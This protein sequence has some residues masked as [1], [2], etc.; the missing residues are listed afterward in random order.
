MTS[1]RQDDFF[2]ALLK[3]SEALLEGSATRLLLERILD[4]AMEVTEAER[5]FLFIKSLQREN[6]IVPSIYRNFDP[7]HFVEKERYSI[8]V[9]EQVMQTGE[10][11][12][13]INAEED[14]RF[15]GRESVVINKLTSIICVPIRKQKSVL[16]YIYLDSQERRAHFNLETLHFMRVFANQTAIALEAADFVNRLALENEALKAQSD[17][18]SPFEEIIGESPE[19]QTI[20]RLTQRVMETDIPV[21]ILGE[22]GTGKELIARAIHYRGARKHKP[23]I[24]QFCGALAD[25]LL[26]SELFGYKKGAF[27]GASK[28][29]PGLLEAADGG[30]FLLDEIA[31]VSL[32][33]QT[34]LLRFLQEGEFR[35][36]GDTQM[37][38]VDTRIIAATNK[39]LKQLVKEGQFREDLYY[40]LNVV[41]IKMPALR[42]RSGDL[43]ILAEHFLIK[44][45]EKYHRNVEKFS[46]EAM[47]AI[48]HHDWPGNVRELQN[49][50]QRAVTLCPGNIIEP[51]HLALG[52][53]EASFTAEPVTM[54]E[55]ERRFVLETLSEMGGN[56]T[57]TAERL[58][59]SLRWLQ[60]RLKEWHVE[61]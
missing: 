5:G 6:D 21:L 2:N 4:I 3:I 61:D 33:I 1:P 48:L 42:E 28:D 26:E 30:T 46:R 43:P 57:K 32:E 24:A 15:K 29:K 14:D 9:L 31:D 18:T 20:F 37:R 52:R 49:A 13:T 50:I 44:Y 34:K 35:R 59:V 51:E 54:A 40:R 36:V 39:D 55:M 10:P 41:T 58:G 47:A 25:N 53:G 38:T 7:R 56:R 22:S 8:G 19:I 17:V 27:T 11:V 45:R 23:F 12:V 16:G 60:Y